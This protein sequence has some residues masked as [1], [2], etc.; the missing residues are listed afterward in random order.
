M[1]FYDHTLP[2]TVLDTGRGGYHAKEID[3]QNHNLFEEIP[4]LGIIGDVLM[5]LCSERPQAQPEFPFLP[6]GTQPRI[7]CWD[8]RGIDDYR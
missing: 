3:E 2:T 8:T 5:N 1:Y 7:T 6:Q 4:S